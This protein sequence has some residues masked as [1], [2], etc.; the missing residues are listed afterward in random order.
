MRLKIIDRLRYGELSVTDLAVS[1]EIS[2]ANPSQ[3]LSVMRQKGTVAARREGASCATSGQKIP[4]GYF[5]TERMLKSL[6]SGGDVATCGSYQET[7]RNAPD[8]LIE[9]VQTGKTN[10]PGEWTAAAEIELI[11]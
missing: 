6:V 3:H 7:C 10:L 1:I 9:G 8:R 11:I 4:D 5:N 2:Q